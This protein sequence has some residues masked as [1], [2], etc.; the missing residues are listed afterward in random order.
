MLHA[1]EL[2]PPVSPPEI[3]VEHRWPESEFYVSEQHRLVYCPIQKVA[4]SSLKLWWAELMEG[5]ADSFISETRYG[6][7][8]DHG[9]LNDRFKL[10]R[11]ARRLGRRPLTDDGWFR[12]V[13]VRN[14]WSRLV[15][16]FANKFVPVHDMA[17]PVFRDVHSRWK[18]QPVQMTGQVV[19]QAL[20]PFSWS[21]RRQ[22]RTSIWPLLRGMKAWH[23]EFTFRHF[24]DFLAGSNLNDVETDMHWRP[25]YQFLGDVSFH[26]VGRFERLEDDMRAISNLLGVSRKVPVTNVT[27]YSR[28]KERSTDCF[29]DMPISELRRLPAIPDYRQ[30]FSR[31]LQQQVAS[32]YQRD[33]EQFGYEFEG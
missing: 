8:I 17:E 14:P 7:T 29:A 10:H 12:I 15:S 28:T 18:T 31:D 3:D 1:T 2:L 25:Q 13:F 16:V 5:T 11:Q 20:A 22:P 33:V 9:G 24:I 21:A 23:D 6:Q 19:L 30:F 26:Y 27:N 32:L 4:C